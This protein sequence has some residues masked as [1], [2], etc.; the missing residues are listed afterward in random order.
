MTSARFVH[1]TVSWL[2]RVE[3]LKISAL[4]WAE[5]SMGIPLG[6]FWLIPRFIRVYSRKVHVRIVGYSV[7]PLIGHW[8]SETAV[9][10]SVT[11]TKV[12]RTLY[13]FL[14]CNTVFQVDCRQRPRQ[15]ARVAGGKLLTS[16][17]AEWSL[18]LSL[19]RK[20]RKKK[21]I[22]L[23]CVEVSSCY[24]LLAGSSAI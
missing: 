22:C 2:R 12:C 1:I 8:Y 24:S 5:L 7:Y 15:V 19:E 17:T 11:F 23:Q 9:D 4:F 13:V 14:S 21:R 18:E 6:T 3:T 10:L 16:W 20:W